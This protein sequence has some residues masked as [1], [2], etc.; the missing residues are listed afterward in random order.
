MEVY[1]TT[2]IVKRQNG[3]PSVSFGN[4][5]DN[6][7]QNS[8]RRFFDDNFW[9]TDAPLTGA[10]VPVNVRETGLH[11]EMDVIAPGCRKEDFMINVENNILTI[12]FTHKDEE[13]EQNEKTGWVRNEYIQQSF[14]RSFTL[15]DTVDLNKITATYK[16]GILQ[17]ILPK[18]EKAQKL[19]KNIEIK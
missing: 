17:L 5:V 13:R 8:L 4:V 18:S 9:D 14:I 1:M 16:D 6:I 7:F 15:D 3:N 10:S 2:A 12:A 11:Y 19:V